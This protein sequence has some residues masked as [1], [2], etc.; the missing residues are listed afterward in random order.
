MCSNFMFEKA[1][2]G[3]SATVSRRFTGQGGSDTFVMKI[4]SN[5]V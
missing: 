1:E 3:G 4:P 2:A 5:K